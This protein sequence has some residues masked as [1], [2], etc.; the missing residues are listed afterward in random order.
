MYNQTQYKCILPQKKER[1]RE[2]EKRNGRGLNIDCYCMTFGYKYLNGLTPFTDNPHATMSQVDVFPGDKSLSSVLGE[3]SGELVRT[4]SPNFVCTKLPSHWRSNKTLPVP[5]KV[6]ALGE[7]KDGTKVTIAC[8]NDE[9]YTGEL[10]NSTAYMKNQMAKFNDLRF[11]GRSGRGKSFTLTIIVAT[12][13]PQITTYTKAIKVTVDGPREARS[14]TK[15]RTDDRRIIHRGPLDIPME[16]PHTDPL[17]DSRRFPP[18]VE[19]EHLRRSTQTA[20]NRRILVPS[21][22]TN[23]FHASESRRSPWGSFESLTPYTKEALFQSSSTVSHPVASYSQGQNTIITPIPNLGQRLSPPEMDVS[24]SRLANV[25]DLQVPATS[26]QDVTAL[27]RQLPLLPEPHR[28]EFSALEPRY[29]G[30]SSLSLMLPPRFQST[31]TD[32]RYP[33]RIPEPR[34]TEP[35]HLNSTISVPFASTS[36]NLAILEESRAIS[37]LANPTNT[38][39]NTYTPMLSSD[40]YNSMNPQSTLASSFT[41]PV[42]PQ[43]S[44]G[45][46]YPHLHSSG[47]QQNLQNSIYLPDG[48]VRTYEILGTRPAGHYLSQRPNEMMAPRQADIQMR[49]DRP[50]LSPTRLALESTQLQSRDDDRNQHT[51]MQT[52]QSPLHDA[53]GHSPPRGRNNGDNGNVWRPY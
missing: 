20:D 51:E 25:S 8:G 9:N 33:E 15:L 17:C 39:S 43:L 31:T 27:E 37:T 18:S 2:S 50:L 12:H 10:R 40:L 14:K 53:P 41:I 23:G 36:T 44:S 13:P 22:D 11:V 38:G 46:I 28:L 6:I 30:S 48:E 45:F 34:F 47:A 52:N 24:E 21:A 19:L 32:L 29:P 16:R 35:R 7:I 5:F 42:S 3:H 4:G 26:Q 49:M 1:E